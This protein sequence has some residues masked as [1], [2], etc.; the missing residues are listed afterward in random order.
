MG[1]GV[2]LRSRAGRKTLFRIA[3]QDWP[4]PELAASVEPPAATD[5]IAPAAF[6]GDC[7]KLA[8]QHL[9]V[10]LSKLSQTRYESGD[11]RVRLM[12]A[13]SAPHIE[14]GDVP[15]F[16]FGLHRAHLEF[17]ETAESPFL[18]LGCSSADTTLLVPLSAI[19]SYLNLLS[20]TK[21]E[22]RQYW[23]VVIQ[24]RMGRFVLR[25]SA[26]KTAPTSPGSTSAAEL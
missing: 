13:V 15:Y 18:C 9:G 11:G 7:V 4:R 19:Q 3:I 20:V 24:K 12:C 21:T 26:A 8:Q 16:W 6:H 10:H 5:K 22:D 23:H 17:L 1:V 25:H 2:R 14:S